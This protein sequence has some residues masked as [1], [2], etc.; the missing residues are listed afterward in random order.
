MLELQGIEFYTEKE[1]KN[2]S[3]S[4]TII[5][6]KS[7]QDVIDFYNNNLHKKE[8]TRLMLGKIGKD[9]GE[10]ILGDTGI[11]IRG[12]NIIINSDF[13]DHHGDAKKE[14]KL[15]QVV[16]NGSE[17]A[18]LP[19]YLENYSKVIVSENKT[20]NNKPRLIFESDINGHRVIIENVSDNKNSIVLQTMYGKAK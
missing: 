17:L 15:N 3:N 19:E 16:I 18:R 12:Y 6:A 8:F 10:R 1:I 7:E 11:N 20:K 4:K 14:E 2:W 5:V 13:E 9:L